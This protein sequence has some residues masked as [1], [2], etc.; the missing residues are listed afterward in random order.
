MTGAVLE[1]YLYFRGDCRAA[2]EF[3][4]GA[5]GGELETQSY[6]DAPGQAAAENPQWL[7]HATLKGGLAGLMGS[8]TP[9]ASERA[10]KGELSLAG[11]DEDALTAAFNALAL[12]G[13][14][15]MPLERQFWGA[16]FGSLTDR[17]GVDWMV[18]IWPPQ[19]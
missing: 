17:F 6:A 15:R 10:A 19:D 13:S 8:D 4:R 2:M 16:T 7:M 5:L 12:G 14:V 9:T 1:P 3:Y 18:N 11:S